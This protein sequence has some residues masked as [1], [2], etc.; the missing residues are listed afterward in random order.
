MIFTSDPLRTLRSSLLLVKFRWIQSSSFSGEVDNVSVNQRPGRPPC[1]SN[2]P[3]A[4]PTKNTNLEEYVEILISVNS[5][6][7]LFMGSEVKSKMWK[8]NNDGRTDN[9]YNNS[10]LK[11]VFGSCARKIT[12]KDRLWDSLYYII[13]QVPNGAWPYVWRSKRCRNVN[14]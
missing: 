6:W 13:L 11:P 12:L 4:S 5:R 7:N 3:S 9:A 10:A 1:F 14:L 2:P 8:K